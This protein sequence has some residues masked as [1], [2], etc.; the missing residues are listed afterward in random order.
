MRILLL[1][2]L[3]GALA[4]CASTRA[5]RLYDALGGEAGVARLVD[6]VTVEYQRDEK[7]G[8]LFEA[9]EIDYF[10][11]RLREQICEIADGGCTYTGLSMNEAHSGLDLSEAQFNDFVAASRRGMDKAGI[12][13]AEQNRLLAR[14]ARMRAD[15]IHQ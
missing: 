5:P 2:I 9:T 1:V 11:E 8:F 3:I 13:I 10:K 6:A 14:L 4:A 12:A 7:I 15:V